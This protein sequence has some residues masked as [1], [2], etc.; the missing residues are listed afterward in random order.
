VRTTVIRHLSRYAWAVGTSAT[1]Y[2]SAT[3]GASTVIVHW[4]GTTWT[5][6]PSPN[7]GSE[8]YLR[9][10]A[11]TSPT[12]A[13]AVGNS[14]TATGLKSVIEH[15]DGTAWTPV[16]SQNSPLYGVA[17]TSPANAWAVGSGQRN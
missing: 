15:W 12:D 17:A 7:P 11:A 5:R 3:S 8:S 2:Y 1:P 16:P 6:I 4:D 14:Y 13:W 9:G 10:V